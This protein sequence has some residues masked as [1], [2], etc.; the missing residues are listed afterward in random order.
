MCRNVSLFGVP[1]LRSQPP[2][3]SPLLLVPWKFIWRHVPWGRPE[4]ETSRLAQNR[5]DSILDI[6]SV[7]RETAEKLREEDRNLLP[8]RSRR[9]TWSS[10][11]HVARKTAVSDHLYSLMHTSRPPRHNP[12]PNNGEESQPPPQKETPSAPTTNEHR[13]YHHSAARAPHEPNSCYAQ[14][15][16]DDTTCV[17]TRWDSKGRVM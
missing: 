7:M 14:Q 3:L 16:A 15:T 9:P 13:A 1:N 8:D 5:I 17:P 12:P 2:W 10:S 11:T 6:C 4:C